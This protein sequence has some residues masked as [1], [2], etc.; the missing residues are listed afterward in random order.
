MR[1][2]IST[3]LY[4]HFPTGGFYYFR[5]NMGSIYESTSISSYYTVVNTSYLLVSDKL[6]LH[7]LSLLIIIIIMHS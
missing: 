7:A 3:I 1:H 4:G 6:E 2:T 5:S